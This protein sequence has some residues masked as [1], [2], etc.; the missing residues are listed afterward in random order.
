MCIAVLGKLEAICPPV[1]LDKHKQITL[2]IVDQGSSVL[3]PSTFGA[4][5]FLGFGSGLCIVGYLAT[6]LGP[7]QDG[8]Q[9]WHLP[10]P[11]HSCDNQKCLQ[12]VPNIPGGQN[13]PWL[14]LSV[15][16]TAVELYS[17]YS[18]EWKVQ[19]DVCII[20]C[21][22]CKKKRNISVFYMTACIFINDFR[23]D[24][25]ETTNTGYPREG[26]SNVMG[27][28][29]WGI[30]FIVELLSCVWLFVTPWTVAR[31]APPSMGFPR[32]DCWSGLPF[33][34]P[35][36]LPDPGIKPLS[37]ALAGFYILWE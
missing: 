6:S 1:G 12:R 32:Q 20:C 28:V 37:P 27:G 35:G 30:S 9:H 23:K 7:T 33:P 19:K 25:Q 34:L 15:S 17:G 14:R 21:H 16:Y 5:I 29:W 4:G 13:H 24:T 11:A 18:K 8:W 22:L 3:A 10:L 36:H 31:W 2:C 26:Q